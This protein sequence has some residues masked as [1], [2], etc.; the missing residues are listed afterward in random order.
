MLF[1]KFQA[2]RHCRHFGYWNA[3]I[4]ATLNLYVAAMPPI[5]F[6][7]NTTYGLGEDVL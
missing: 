2:G 3:T 7:L 6:H 1:K 5:K 4:L